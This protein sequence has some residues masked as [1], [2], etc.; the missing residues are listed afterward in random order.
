MKTIVRAMLIPIL[1][2]ATALAAER[3]QLTD[4]PFAVQ[5]TIGIQ[6]P[7]AKVSSVES[8]TEDGKVVYKVEFTDSKRFPDL[9]VASDG[10]VVKESGGGIAKVFGSSTM[11]LNELPIP[12]QKTIKSEVGAGEIAQIKETKEQ[13]KQAFE[14]EFS[15]ADKRETLLV[16]SDGQILKDSRKG[17]AV[18]ESAGAQRGQLALTD[19]P[20][21]VQDAILMQ[22]QNDRLPLKG[23]KIK[24]DKEKGEFVYKVEFQ[25]KGANTKL[26]LKAD[27]SLLKQEK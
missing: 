3:V 22:S 25:E 4:T 1:A 26:W 8:K 10:S 9:W 24:R 23:I 17:F 6:R 21:P 15:Q 14:V 13:G 16:S 19:V 11:A 20:K 27:G 5:K 12:A 2:S 7:S 18:K